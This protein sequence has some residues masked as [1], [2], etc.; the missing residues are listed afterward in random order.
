MTTVHGVT[1]ESDTTQQLN[2]QQHRCYRPSAYQSLIPS[3]C[4][5][6]IFSAQ[7]KILCYPYRW[8]QLLHRGQEMVCVFW[9]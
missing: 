5:G 1:K 4:C 3:G 6:R 2:N 9:V 8:R 7:L